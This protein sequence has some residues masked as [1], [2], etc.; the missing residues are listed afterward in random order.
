MRSRRRRQVARRCSDDSVTLDLADASPTPRRPRNS[1]RSLTDRDPVPNFNSIVKHTYTLDV[2]TGA[3]KLK[4]HAPRPLPR[5][6][7]PDDV[8]VSAVASAR[9]EVR[10]IGAKPTRTISSASAPP[11]TGGAAAPT[12][13]CRLLLTSSPT[14]P[15]ALSCMAT[16][17]STLAFTPEH[18]RDPARSRS[19]TPSVRFSTHASAT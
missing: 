18:G 1:P 13:P 10:Y 2:V 9:T 14:L 5:Y 12:P 11:A 17:C 7:H 8:A 4:T 3:L 16:S 6:S 19:L 15:S